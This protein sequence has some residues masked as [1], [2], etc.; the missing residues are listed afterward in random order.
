MLLF[1]NGITGSL[2]D[3]AMD[4][5]DRVERRLKL[6]DVRVLMSV[7]QA[8]SMSKAAASTAIPIPMSL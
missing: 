4:N 2:W 1:D 8:G 7:V 3:T 5:T 6:H